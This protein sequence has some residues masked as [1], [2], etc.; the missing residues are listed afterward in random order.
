MP[1]RYMLSSCVRP[2]VCLSVRSS[3]VGIVPKRLNIES[4]EQRRTITQGL[5]FSYAKYLGEVPIVMQR[6]QSVEL[7]LNGSWVQMLLGAKAA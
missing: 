7:A 5:Y 4:R 1:A 6:V 3:Q 2:S